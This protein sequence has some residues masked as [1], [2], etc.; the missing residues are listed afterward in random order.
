MYGNMI[1]P[2]VE[3]H[4]DLIDDA[5]DPGNDADYSDPLVLPVQ[6][7]GDVAAP[8]LA[9]N[10]PPPDG[11]TDIRDVLAVITAIKNSTTAPIKARADLVGGTP[12]PNILNGIVNVADILFIIRG[13][14]NLKYAFPPPVPCGP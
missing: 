2:G 10:W 1:V 11:V 7:Y 4:I 9:T 8:P 13:I 5:C 14:R 12:N 3:Y 6:K